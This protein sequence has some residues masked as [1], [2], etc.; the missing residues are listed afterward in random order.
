M[1]E[2]KYLPIFNKCL[3]PLIMYLLF[4]V[5]AQ[6]KNLSSSGSSQ[7]GSSK[8]C[9]GTSSAS[10]KRSSRI[11][12][13]LISPNFTERV[14]ITRLYSSMIS[15]D[16]AIWIRS[17]CQALRIREG[18]PLKNIP[19]TKTFVSI[20]TFVLTSCLEL[21]QSHLKYL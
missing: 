15:S 11:G 7:T 13:M 14:S 4:E 2:F 1:V 19:E 10:M 5:I 17:S 6:A 3:S 21:L 20:T 12:S 18:G 9:E 16:T 8:E